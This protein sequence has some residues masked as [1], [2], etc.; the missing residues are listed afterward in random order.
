MVIYNPKDWFKLI[1]QFH[2]SDTFRML[3]PAM[4]G[5]G[6]LTGII[7]YVIIGVYHLE[8]KSTIMIHSLLGFVLSLLLV[9][10]TNTAYDRWWEGRKMWGGFVNSSRALAIK[11]AAYLPET[12]KEERRKLAL[13]LANYF[14]ASKDHLR[15]EVHADSWE[16]IPGIDN[17]QL[18]LKNHVPNA[19]MALFMKE[20]VQLTRQGKLSETYLRTIDLEIRNFSENLGACE[21]IRNTPIPYSYSLFIKKIIFLYCI[22]L[23]FGLISDF[24]YWTIPIA[25]LV[26]YAFASL[27]VIAEE[28]EDPFGTDSNDLPTDEIAERIKGNL[29]ELLG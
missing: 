24:G 18:A 13:L 9:F 5:L 22:S 2:K 11:L 25:M 28:I 26:F 19:I 14:T 10:R 20:I 7:E 1:F 17:E 29:L 21:R 12:E 23:P 4:L 3:T 15:N 16:K 8:F 27:E 6:L